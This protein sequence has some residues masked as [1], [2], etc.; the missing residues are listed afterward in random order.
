MS[1]TLLAAVSA[2]NDA[3]MLVTA[4]TP[5]VEQAKAAGL[6]DDHVFTDE[7]ETDGPTDRD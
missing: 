6:G 7:G 5:L 1:M 2:I 4:L 3:S